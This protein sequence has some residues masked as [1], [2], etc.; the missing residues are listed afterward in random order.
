MAIVEGKAGLENFPFEKW[1]IMALLY[2]IGAAIYVARVPEKLF[3]G[4]FDVWVSRIT[5]IPLPV[6]KRISE[7]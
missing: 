7:K 4:T 1:S 3:P 2:L 6:S 5:R